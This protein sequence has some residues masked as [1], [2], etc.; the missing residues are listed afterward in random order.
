MHF[1]RILIGWFQTNSVLITI[2]PIMGNPHLDVYSF[3]VNCLIPRKKNKVKIKSTCTQKKNKPSSPF[4][5]SDSCQS[6]C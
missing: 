3:T 4:I 1:Y 6:I 2:Q 5:L